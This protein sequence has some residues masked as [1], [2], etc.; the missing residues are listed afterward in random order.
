MRPSSPVTRL[1]T[2]LSLQASG[3]VLLCPACTWRLPEQEAGGRDGLHPLSCPASQLT[4]CLLVHSLRVPD[5]VV[6]IKLVA[7]YLTPPF[8]GTPTDAMGRVLGGRSLP[9]WGWGGCFLQLLQQGLCTEVSKWAGSSR[10]A[11]AGGADGQE[12]AAGA[13]G[14]M[15]SLPAAWGAVSPGDS[16]TRVPWRLRG[17]R[18]AWPQEGADCRVPASR[19]HPAR[20]ASDLSVILHPPASSSRQ[21]W[22]SLQLETSSK[23]HRPGIHTPPP[24]CPVTSI[25]LS[26]SP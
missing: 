10:E 21:G 15:C 16:G 13:E 12:A 18:L 19:R 9:G 17:G 6:L 5:A 23:P 20:G 1:L 24:C 22:L 26:P 2:W 8:P 14:P 4:L 7:P 11:G 3:P 25:P